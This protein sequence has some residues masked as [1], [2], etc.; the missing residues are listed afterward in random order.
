MCKAKD[1]AI[2]NN[3]RDELIQLEEKFLKEEKK[4]IKSLFYKSKTNKGYF[5]NDIITLLVNKYD[6]DDLNNNFLFLSIEDVS[7]F[8]LIY[9]P[10]DEENLNKITLTKIANSK[11]ILLAYDTTMKSFVENNNC[12][13]EKL[14]EIIINYINTHEIYFSYFFENVHGCTIHTWNIFINLKYIKEYL[15]KNNE[16]NK[17]IIRTKI[18]LVFLHEFNHV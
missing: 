7:P 2:K 3:T 1:Y 17:L 6:K 18:L 11:V 14:K 15:D 16:A 10:F 8:T 13:K 4:N 12:T 5:E 9:I